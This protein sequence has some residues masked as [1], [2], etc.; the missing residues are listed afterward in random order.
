VRERLS[1]LSISRYFNQL[2]LRRRVALSQLPLSLMVLVISTTAPALYPRL[3]ENGL[4]QFSLALH[5]IL[6]ILCLAVPWERMRP[7]AYL[8]IPVADFAVIAVTREGA[9][10]SL[11]GLGLLA[12][13]P[14]IWLAASGIR[15]GGIL[16]GVV[17]SWLIV[18]A[19]VLLHP[20]ADFASA[21]AGTFLLPMG[22]LTIGLAIRFAS[23]NLLLQQ[24]E[25][26]R[27]DA[28]MRALL[29]ESKDRERL[30]NTILETVDVGVVAVNADGDHVLTNRQQRLFQELATPGDDASAEESR[31]LVFGQ[32]RRTPLPPEKRPLHRATRGETYSGQLLWFGEGAG[33]RAVS[34]AGRPIRNEDGEFTGSVIVFSDVTELVDALSAK[35][36][37]VSNV[38]HEFRTPL[39]SILGYLDLALDDEDEL[40]AYVRSYLAT[41]R[42]NAERL[43]TLVSDLLVTASG[44][45]SVHPH[46]TDL[47]GLVES[48]ISSAQ[49]HASRAGL[50]LVNEV[51]D[52]LWAYADPV[53]VSQVLDN[54][55]S[56]AIKYSPDGG[57][58]TVRARDR[59]DWVELAVQDT[60][61]GMTAEDASQVFSRFFRTSGARESSIPGAGLGLSITK[62]II[63]SHGGTISC[64]SALGIGTTFTVRLP[65][66]GAPAELT[67]AEK[68]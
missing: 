60:G 25:L 57:T 9:I 15:R 48:S 44:S 64:E 14:V 13:F 19:P 38:S 47:S 65:L 32:D 6:L 3:L 40:P 50:A 68:S 41:A 16:I 51:S 31:L 17:G 62:A 52:P 7:G 35:D 11:P 26:E 42:R 59:D 37:F 54:L 46:P 55:L 28:E 36:A 23:A 61:M 49:A 33:Q 18:L 5:A 63:E 12:I 30:L 39:T 4:F 43:L 24:R 34:A 66:S 45:M 10:D 20:Q 67:V 27:K 21:F 2:S 29:A 8:A 22:M 53:R 1:T 58:V 56:N